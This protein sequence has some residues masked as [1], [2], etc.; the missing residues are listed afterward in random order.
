MGGLHQLMVNWW[1]GI[2]GVPRSNKPLRGSKRNPYQ[3]GPK[4]AIWTSCSKSTQEK[5]PNHHQSISSVDNAMNPVRPG[6]K[7]VTLSW[8][9][10]RALSADELS[11]SVA[12]IPPKY[13]EITGITTLRFRRVCFSMSLSVPSMSETNPA[14]NCPAPSIC[15][16]CR[17]CRSKII[18]TLE[19]LQRSTKF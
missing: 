1:F 12:S 2:P 6:L 13:G 16:V 19:I 7:A 9:H 3:R 8:A 10:A 15:N 18:Q 11:S 5:W 17:I 4:P 14:K